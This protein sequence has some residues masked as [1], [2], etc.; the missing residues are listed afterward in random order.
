MISVTEKE[1]EEIATRYKKTPAIIKMGKLKRAQVQEALDIQ[2][3][4]RGP[5]GSILVELGY[6]T[7]DEL[8]IALGAQSGMEAVQ[9]GKMEVPPEVIAVMTSQMATTYRVVPFD[10]DPD[11]KTLSLALDNPDNFVATDDLK[12]LLGYNIKACLCTTHIHQ[13]KGH[14]NIGNGYHLS[15]QLNAQA[16]LQF[17]PDHHQGAYKLAADSCINGNA[18]A[19][20]PASLDSQGWTG[21][22]FQIIYTCSQLS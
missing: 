12:T 11:G 8:N 13:V 2:K 20:Y 17:W 9:L 3:Q 14:F 5:I 16:T 10:L 18:S 1:A 6:I 22:G 4:R 19:P 21:L 15:F 7:D